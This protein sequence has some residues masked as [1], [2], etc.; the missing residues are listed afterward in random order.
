MG[1]INISVTCKSTLQYLYENCYTNRAWLI[2]EFLAVSPNVITPLLNI[3]LRHKEV[4]LNQYLFI[5]FKKK[6]NRLEGE[7]IRDFFPLFFFFLL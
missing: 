6:K 1:I 7:K 3:C 4:K 5:K 2:H